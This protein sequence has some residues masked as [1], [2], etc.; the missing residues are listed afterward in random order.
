MPGA[1]SGARM[2]SMRWMIM[3]TVRHVMHDKYCDL[4]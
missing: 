2:L 1:V 3:A 4:V